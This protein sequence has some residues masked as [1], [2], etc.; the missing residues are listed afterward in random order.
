MRPISTN[1]EFFMTQSVS[2]ATF[3]TDPASGLE[4]IVVAHTSLSHVDGLQGE[5]VLRG[6]RI[7]ELAGVVS[8][9]CAVSHLW[10]DLVPLP[11]GA[12]QGAFATARVN[13]VAAFEAMAAA[14]ADLSV[15]DLMRL[16]LCSVP[17]HPALPA[18]VWVSGALPVLLAA[19]AR[20]KKGL[21]PVQPEPALGTAADL[22]RILT[23]STADDDSVRTLDR[24]LVTILDHGLNAS[25]FT[26]RVI[27]STQADMRDAVL[28]AIGALKGPL[29]GGAPGPVLDMLDDIGTPENA[30]DWISDQLTKGKRLMGFGH[31]IYRTR[32]PRADVLKAGLG[33]LP[34][35]NSRITEA[36][37]IE[38]AAL[39]A[40]ARAKP[41]RPL[42]TNV[43]FY[44]AVLL[45]A[46]GMDRDLFTPLFAVGRAPG[47]CGHV[48]EQQQTGKLIRPASDYIGPQATV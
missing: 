5:L 22:L 37:A 3:N 1:T 41:D 13:A 2:P 24:Y 29:H 28:G 48:I 42:D 26:A 46:I 31:R 20:L 43:E 35:G 33:L 9:E 30:G 23:G 17:T 18:A 8:F 47:W 34:P 4:G 40:L 6:K 36:A 12:L 7:E 44:T 25:T 15:I 16:G 11:D 10:A 14:P 38:R 27:A 32:D 21:A 45:D 19:A 39:M